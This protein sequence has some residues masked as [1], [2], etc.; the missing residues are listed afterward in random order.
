MFTPDGRLMQVE[1]ATTAATAYST[2]ICLV[3][4]TDDLILFACPAKKKT[5]TT[6]TNNGNSSSVASVMDRLIVL[7]QPG[8][9][10]A[11]TARTTPALSSRCTND[12]IDDND[13]EDEDFESAA[14]SVSPTVILATSGVLADGLALLQKLQ[15]ELLND[16]LYLG[17]KHRPT[18][19]YVAETLAG[20][21][22]HNCL[23]GGVRPYGAMLWTIGFSDYVG[24]TT[25]ERRQR[26]Y[27]EIFQ[28][29]PSGGIVQLH[30]PAAGDTTPLIL[31]EGGND[32]Q[33]LVRELKKTLSSAAA[34]RG[35]AP[36]GAGRR[37][38]HIAS[39]IGRVAKL[40]RS[41]DT[42][43]ELMLLSSSRG[44]LKLNKEQIQ[45]YVRQLG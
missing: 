17:G 18:P 10:A 1:Y 34:Q 23:N 20:Y 36:I 31:G 13:Q 42:E 12:I 43:S 29:S 28:T 21:I 25:K 22:Q 33:E 19:M 4:L 26:R 24:T 32:G 7:L 39:T 11:A 37:N 44:A 40:L 9:T 5:T 8:C 35:A 2:P 45:A 41:G 30:L 14:A 27:L 6:T 16:V 15:G 3:R 38:R